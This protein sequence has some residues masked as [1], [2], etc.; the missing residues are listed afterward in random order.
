M[1]P[2]GVTTYYD[3][4]DV[5]QADIYLG[6]LE[7]LWAANASAEEWV[8]VARRGADHSQAITIFDEHL[9]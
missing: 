2:G 3:W 1:S 8:N 5:H 6:E 4:S 7:D 9:Y